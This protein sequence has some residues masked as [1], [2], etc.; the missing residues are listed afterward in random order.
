MAERL[1]ERAANETS[2]SDLNVAALADL[3]VGAWPVVL[4]ADVGTV[5][6]AFVT[7]TVDG[8]PTEAGGR[9]NCLLIPAAVEGVEA[10][11]IS[12]WRRS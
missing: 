8:L 4:C 12:R 10:E 11:A 3:K 6:E 5:D 9:L 7:T 2:K 1:G